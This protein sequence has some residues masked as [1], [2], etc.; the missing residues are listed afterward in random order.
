MRRDI[1][2]YFAKDD[3]QVEKMIKRRPHGITA[4][5][6]KSAASELYFDLTEGRRQMEVRER[7]WHIWSRARE[8][9]ERDW[10]AEELVYIRQLEL[11]RDDG[12]WAGAVLAFCITMAILLL[13]MGLTL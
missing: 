7:V 12:R 6:V 4:N 10:A 8:M 13:L 11:E 3:Q 2:D 9:S 1:L 5:Q